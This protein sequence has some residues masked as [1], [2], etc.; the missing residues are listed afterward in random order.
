M[1]E[2]DRRL[3]YGELLAASARLCEQLASEGAVPGRTVVLLLARSTEMVVA[4]VAC[5]RLGVTFVPIDLR[6]PSA[7]TELIASVDFWIAADTCATD[8][9]VA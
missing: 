5:A 6:Q 4:Q 2:G 1:I 3:S 8:C 7:R 9:P